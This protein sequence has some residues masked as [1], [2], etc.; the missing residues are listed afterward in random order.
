MGE[1]KVGTKEE[2]REA[3][4]ALREREKE[5][6]RLSEELAE[7]RRALPWVRVEKEYR[8]ATDA[9]P[10][11]LPELFEG[12][13]QLLIYHLMFGPNYSGGA[14]PGCSGLAD[15]LDGAVVHLNHR[16][17]T[18]TCV[19]RA[20]LDMIQ[21]YKRRMGWRFPWASAHGSE[22]PSDFGFALT[23]EQIRTIPQVA[24]MVADPPEFLTSWAEA[25]GTDL[26]D[27][28]Q[29]GPGWNVFALEDGVVYHTYSLQPPDRNM[30]APYYYQLL[31]QTPRGRV[32]E[33]DAVRHDEY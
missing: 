29:E 1:H 21:A 26:E 30:V 20:P 14:C 23:P 12:R 11:T 24:E 27:G 17:V 13:S 32:R 16:D 18:L 5:L 2:W 9:G 19:S 28:L 10:K 8:L 22:F 31:D 25:V 3:R 15:H 6:D 33:M 7:Q 4:N